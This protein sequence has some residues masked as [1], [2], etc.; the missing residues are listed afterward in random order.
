MKMKKNLFSTGNIYRTIHEIINIV[1]D[2]YTLP[3]L[4][5]MQLQTLKTAFSI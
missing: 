2:M 5:F 1:T 3:G 4:Y